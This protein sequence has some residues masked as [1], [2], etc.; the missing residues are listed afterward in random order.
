MSE[1]KVTKRIINYPIGF[2]PNY[3]LPDEYQPYRFAI[4][5]LGKKPLVAICMN[6]SA[7]RENTSDSTVNRIIGYSEKLSYDGWVIFNTYPERAT[8]AANMESFNKALNDSNLETIKNF[9]MENEVKEVLGAWG[10]LK[11]DSLTTGKNAIMEMLKKLD[12]KVFHFGTLTNQGNP[13]HPLQRQEKW[14]ISKENKN[15]Y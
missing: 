13:R 11:Y 4:G 10:D 7:A 3:I 6:P 14:E 1:N 12:V 5:K 9:I 2:E 8:D 15:Y